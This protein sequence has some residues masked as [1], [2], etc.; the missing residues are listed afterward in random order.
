VRLRAAIRDK[1]TDRRDEIPLS[2]G[3]T[4]GLTE[5][6]LP[7][8]APQRWA[9]AT[10]YPA[11]LVE[12]WRDRYGDAKARDLALHGVVVPP[13]VLNT[14]FASGEPI[15]QSV[16][17][18]QEGFRIYTGGRGGLGELL[19]GRRDLWVQDPASA[20]VIAEVAR[21]VRSPTPPR[22]IVDL[23]AGRGTKTR[24]LFHGFPGAT[25]VATDTD[26]A[27]RGS[28][29]E[30]FRGEKRVQVVAPGHVASKFAGKADLVLLDVPCSNT[31]VLA[32]RVE[33]KYRFGDRSIAQL[34]D[35]QRRIIADG[36]ALLGPGGWL[37]YSTCS[38]EAEENESQAE[39]AAKT[40]GLTPVSS[41][42]ETPVGLPGEDPAEYR[43]G[44]YAAL[45][46]R[47]G[48]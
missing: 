38:L 7:E 29:A 11:R 25:I 13:V 2:D 5:P 40:F 15:L 32:R 18:S 22:L 12:R 23:C 28:L 44:S 46:R 34:A 48:R 1:G 41:S 9:A 6:I 19:S 3:R 35:L 21:P 33:A 45:L 14:T 31:G 37:L 42:L 43:D 10:G 16:P 8:P 27:R 36:A 30:V 26:D 24:Q 20:R 17:H 4:L 47:E 39:F